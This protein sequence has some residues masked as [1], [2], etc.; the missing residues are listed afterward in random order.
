MPDTHTQILDLAESAM[1]SRGYHAVSFRDL[2]DA[3]GIKSASIH[4]HFRHKEDLGLALVDRYATRFADFLGPT[5][6]QSWPDA[7][8]HF[9]AGYQTALQ[10][11]DLQCLCGL[12]AA[13]TI[14]LP[15]PV[16]TRVSRFFE[17]NLAWLCATMPDSITDKRDQ[18][19][20][21]Q[22]T[23]QGAVTLSV[24]L[25]D[26]AILDGI[27]QTLLEQARSRG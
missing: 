23:L 6:N 22:S 18:A 15:E 27:S 21:I 13:E 12:L 17:D 24:T 4:Y 14:G 2:A 16:A 25:G 9:A 1:R 7:V 26:H 10:S 5:E 19:L 8:S 3:L 20:I 11:S